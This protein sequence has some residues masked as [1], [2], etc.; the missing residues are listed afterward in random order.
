M[1]RLQAGPAVRVER[2]VGW[3]GAAATV[4]LVFVGVVVGGGALLGARDSPHV[5][6][7]VLATALVAL[8]VEPVRAGF[9]RLTAQ[10]VHRPAQSPYDVLAQFSSAAG[11]E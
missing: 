5:G 3:I 4:F 6:L 10:I 1:P 7:S 2:V 9:E 8:V 11:T